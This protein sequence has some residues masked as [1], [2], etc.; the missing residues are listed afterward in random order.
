MGKNNK[1]KPLT[2]D[3]YLVVVRNSIGSNLFRNFY[4][5][6][7]GKREDIM[8]N[9]DLSCAFFV[10]S[11]LALFKF[12]KEVHGTVDSTVK[13][14]RESGWIE[15]Q[16]PEIGS[17][18]VWGKVDFG[19]NDIHKHIGFYVG[20]DEAIS[21]SFKLGHPVSHNWNFNNT[22]KVDLIFWNPKIQ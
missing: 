1:L 19:D 16:K 14:L 11:V 7:N 6:V 8:R 3:T 5:E 13:D 22:R 20:N 12:I 4:A 21:N 18:L 15:I 2:F 10:S 17:I 9:G